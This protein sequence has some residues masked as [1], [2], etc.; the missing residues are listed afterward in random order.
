M[1]ISG[2]LKRITAVLLSAVFLAAAMPMSGPSV[3]AY[4]KTVTLSTYGKNQIVCGTSATLQLAK[5]WKSC[6]LK[7]SNKAVASV[8]KSGK[9]KAKKLGVATITAAY[10]GSKT[11]YKVTVIP[12]NKSD[13]RVSP[14]ILFFGQKTKLGLSSDRY[15]TSN[16]RLNFGNSDDDID[17]KGN[18][19]LK[20]D[21]NYDYSSHSSRCY[22]GTYSIDYS[23][24]IFDKKELANHLLS[25]A[26]DKY[27]DDSSD[28][29]T[30]LDAGVGQKIE[31]RTWDEKYTPSIFAREGI[32]ITVDGNPVADVETFSPGSHEI[33]VAADGMEPYSR[34]FSV[35]YSVEDTLT[36]ADAAGWPEKYKSVFDA[37]FAAESSV[38]NAGMSEREKVK[39]IHD[40]LIYHANYVNNGDYESAENWAYGATGVLQHGEGVCQSYALA[41]Y[42]MARAAGLECHYVTGTTV[43]SAGSGVGHAWN[44]VKVDG[45]WYYIDC[46]WDDPVGG[47]HERYKYYL[48]ET[49][50]SD[51]TQGSES[52]IATDTWNAANFGAKYDWMH[53]VLTDE[54]Y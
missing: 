51:H 30:A 17:S 43:N 40:Y 35:S 27:N 24:I 5:G 9:V 38:V 34:N 12:E 46:T 33:T 31:A 11:R 47:G 19:Y 39:A 41:F 14:G 50:W 6:S 16:V 45:K 32:S 48:S 10:K 15:D 42:M 4:A 22:Y 1:R 21:E 2:Y 36:H 54:G 53:Y 25:D 26:S 28:F 8:S 18:F 49:L 52:D 7:S 20:N 29:L 3:T 13:V 23:L 44:R 37:A